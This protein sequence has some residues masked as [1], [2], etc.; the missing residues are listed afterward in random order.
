MDWKRDVSAFVQLAACQ[1]FQ[2]S[3]EVRQEHG[4]MYGA[5]TWALVKVLRSAEGQG[6]TYTGIIRMIGR[7]HDQVP[8]VI[9]DRKESRLWFQS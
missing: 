2:S 6:Q 7:L 9:G 8:K 4:R 5:F 3:R 1:D